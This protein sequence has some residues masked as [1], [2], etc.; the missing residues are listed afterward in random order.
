MLRTID[1]DEIR[2]L[3]LDNPPVNAL[4]EELLADLVRALRQ[5][6]ADGCRAVVISG[7][8]GYFS[9]GLDVPHLLGA[10]VDRARAT[11]ERLFELLEA[12]AVAPIPVV[13]AVTGHSPAGGAVLTLFCDYRVMA[14]G[15]YVIGLNEVQVGLPIPALIHAALARLVG[16][17][18][19]TRL[20]MEAAFLRPHEAREIGL[21]DAVVAPGE[22]TK[23]ALAWC[24][25]VL[26]LPREALRET[27][28]MARSDLRAAL[29]QAG[30]GV[31]R[32]FSRA[33][34]SAETQAAMRALVERLKTR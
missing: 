17:H 10:G 2:E 3:R 31:P 15:E 18:R 14:E 32:E 29:E 6:P 7:S 21:V 12:L 11:F 33:W 34:A 25:R 5:A 20:C 4:R 23:A 26:A 22:V 24:E 8:P 19:A 13:A 30:P 16:A 28:A 1:H 9:A 27:R